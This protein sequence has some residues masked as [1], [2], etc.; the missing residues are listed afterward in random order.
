M[1]DRSFGLGDRCRYSTISRCSLTPKM[2]KTKTF[3]RFSLRAF[4]IATTAVGIAI[5][6]FAQRSRGQRFQIHAQAVDHLID[7]VG[8]EIPEIEH[9]KRRALRVLASGKEAIL[10]HLWAMGQG[11]GLHSDAKTENE[12]L[13]DDLKLQL[14]LLTRQ[15]GSDHQDVEVLKEIVRDW[16]RFLEIEESGRS[17]VSVKMKWR[18][19]D[20]ENM[21]PDEV[22]HLF[23]DFLEKQLSDLKRILKE[24]T[25]RL[26]RFREISNI[27]E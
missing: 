13:L 16:E 9:R 11:G 21:E 4:L 6:I 15:L 20:S 10:G 19:P 22:L 18:T 24:N 3:A 8:L 1:D 17:W 12:L 26:A 14:K 7:E 2:P 25:R 23:V 5:G 27:L